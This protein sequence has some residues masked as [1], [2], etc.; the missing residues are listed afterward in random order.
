MTIDYP[1]EGSTHQLRGLWKEAFGDED[2]FLDAFF[3]TGFSPDRCRCVTLDGQIAA[4]LYW[5]DCSWEGRPLAYL[6]AVATGK[7]YRGQGLCRRLMANTHEHLKYL[8]YTGAVLVPG[9]PSLFDFYGK[10]DYKAFG[11]VE[12]FSCHAEEPPV[13]LRK[14]EA[15]EYARLRRL[16]LPP[17]SILQEGE[18][19]TFLDALGEFY[20]GEEFLMAGSRDGSHW[21]A[22]EFLGNIRRAPGILCALGLQSGHFRTP[23]NGRKNAM[24]LP[25]SPVDTLPAYLG[26]PL[27]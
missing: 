19:L 24:I 2:A 12:D 11:P 5:F 13:P 25:F 22:Q 7:P 27:D 23:G 3:D 1:A 6:Y 8:G 17:G 9:E 15:G 21:Q 14:I 26:L 18:L 16:R 20:A 10:M 4:A